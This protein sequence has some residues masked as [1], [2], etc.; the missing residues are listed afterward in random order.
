M[1][2]PA[3]GKRHL[4]WVSRSRP[5]L[6]DSRLF[7]V[8]PW[9]DVTLSSGALRIN[10]KDREKP[11]CKAP[12]VPIEMQF[13]SNKC[14]QFVLLRTNR[15]SNQKQFAICCQMDYQ[16]IK[17]VSASTHIELSKSAT[18]HGRAKSNCVQLCGTAFIRTNT[19][20]SK[21]QNGLLSLLAPL[22]G[23]GTKGPLPVWLHKTKCFSFIYLRFCDLSPP[24]N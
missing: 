3:G 24:N 1:D 9:A 17:L 18:D 8:V 22:G 19:T 7:F 5:L 10:K 12:Y 11:Y 15:T 23:Y 14:G 20:S 21:N 4:L 6:Y 16:K 13:V 2:V